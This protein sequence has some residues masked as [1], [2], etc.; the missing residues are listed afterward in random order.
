MRPALAS[1]ARDGRDR[2][3]LL[4]QKGPGLGE[5][6]LALDGLPVVRPH[7]PCR[8]GGNHER[9]RG[10]QAEPWHRNL[11]HH[12]ANRGREGTVAGCGRDVNVLCGEGVCPQELRRT[13]YGVSY[14]GGAFTCHGLLANP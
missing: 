4:G 7:A 6:P 14:G 11:P 10:R 9:K 8:A 2:A 3:R 5:D 12:A 1:R 13:Q